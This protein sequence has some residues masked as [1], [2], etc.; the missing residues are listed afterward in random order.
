MLKAGDETTYEVNGHTLILRPIPYG[1]LKKV[2]AAIAKVFEEVSKRTDK[3]DTIQF[4]QV[5]PDLIGQHVATLFP[6]LFDPKEHPFLNGE[7]VDENLTVPMAK[8]IME[9]AIKVNGLEDFFKP[10]G[11]EASRLPNGNQPKETRELSETTASI[12]LENHGSTISAVS[13]TD[14]HL[15]RSTS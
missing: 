11:A 14:G 6:L 2:L 1:R 7:W 3:G 10:K 9:D 12:P 15:S 8:Q 4:I 5:L 13:P